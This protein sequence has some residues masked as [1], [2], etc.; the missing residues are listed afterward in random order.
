VRRGK[1]K[2]GEIRRKREM[3]TE[4]RKRGKFVD[5][6]LP[7]LFGSYYQMH[8]SWRMEMDLPI[9]DAY[10]AAQWLGHL[11]HYLGSPINKVQFFFLI[12]PKKILIRP[13]FF[14]T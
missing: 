8:N 13:K 2:E 12:R 6:F 3:K 9:E 4:K 14:L 11:G 1:G 7:M 10:R 5:S